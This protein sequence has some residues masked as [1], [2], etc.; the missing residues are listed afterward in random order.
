MDFIPLFSSDHLRRAPLGDKPALAIAFCPVTRI[1][2][3]SKLPLPRRPPSTVARTHGRPLFGPLTFR[4]SLADAVGFSLKTP[5]SQGKMTVNNSRVALITGASRGIGASVATILADRGFSIVINYHSKRSR[6][7]AVAE[8][9]QARGGRALI[10]QADLTCSDETSAMVRDVSSAFGRVDALVLNASGGLEKGKPSDYAMD[11][12]LTAQVRLVDASLPL[13]TRGGRIVFVTSHMAHFYAKRGMAGPYQ[14]VAA[15]KYA[16][17][18]ALRARQTEFAG[19]DIALAVVSGDMI[20]GTITP[21][22][23]E[24]MDRGTT[25]ARLEQVGTLP[26]VAEF[27]FAIAEAV[28]TA[29]PSGHTVFVGSTD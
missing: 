13:I 18:Q 15:S 16:G 5:V 3:P 21:R 8:E 29:H 12:N 4:H 26:T 19:R 17:E 27:A 28:T 14:P 22:L 11:L 25:N 2:Q 24:R 10:V 23:L 9:V 6:A 1:E 7:E 20:E